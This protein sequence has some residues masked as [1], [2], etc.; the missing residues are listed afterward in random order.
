MKKKHW[1]II[2]VII[3][4]L[5]IWALCSRQSTQT[6]T[7]KPV[8]KIG[9]SAPFTGDVAFLGDAVKN[10][11]KMFTNDFDSKNAYYK[12]AFIMEDNQYKTANTATTVNKMIS[13]DKVNAVLSYMSSHGFVVNPIAEK[14]KTIHFSISTD[15][16]VARGDYNFI[17]STSPD[18]EIKLIL[19]YAQK[20]LNAKTMV[21]VMT[22][23]AGPE[24][25]IKSL[26]KELKNRPDL[27]LL[28]VYRVNPTEKD[29]KTIIQKISAT[30]PDVLM[31]LLF[32]PEMMTFLKQF[33]QAGIKTQMIGAE[34]FS[35]LEDKSAANN[36]VYADAAPATDSF[37]KRYKKTFQTDATNYAEY[38]YAMLQILTAAFENYAKPEI[39]NSEVLPLIIKKASGIETSVGKIITYPNGIVDAP[40]ILRIIKN[41][42]AEIL[43]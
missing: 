23:A 28:N 36:S 14:T 19:D 40:A 8:V 12:Y 13:G 9:I 16:D 25:F 32:M 39:N 22:N 31:N 21:I 5:I 27:K 11:V 29:F 30:N 20:K 1:I 6:Y 15:P 10:A 18:A 24:V 43:K 38:T 42:K 7:D 37:A 34:S 26:N 4:G 3:I 2:S 41:G 33:N 17:L 35:F